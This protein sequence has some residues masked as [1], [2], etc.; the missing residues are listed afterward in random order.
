M[1]RIYGIDTERLNFLTDG[2]Y[3]I[4]ITLLVLEIKVPEGLTPDQLVS[5]LIHETPKFAVYLIA[6]S[7]CAVGWTF[8]YLANGIHRRTGPAHLFCTLIGLLSVGL[9][10]FSSALMGNYPDQPWGIVAYAIDVGLLAGV[11]GLDLMLAM[12]TLPDH[13]D[14]SPMRLLALTAFAV[15]GEAI[16]C[17]VLAFFSPRACLYMICATTLVIWVEYFVLVGWMGRT[18]EALHEEPH[19]HAPPQPLARRRR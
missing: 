17:G 5:V 4:A 15:T 6:F 2:V 9:I 8:T 12:A 1:R 18:M 7:A 13:V 16:F 3:A 11:Y 14:R 19:A 10:P